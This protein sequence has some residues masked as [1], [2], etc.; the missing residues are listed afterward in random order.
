LSAGEVSRER[1]AA[2]K[3]VLA[4]QHCGNAHAA[5]GARPASST[6]ANGIRHGPY[7]PPGVSP[8]DAVALQKLHPGGGIVRRS[9]H[10]LALTY[11]Q[12][13]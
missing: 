8:Q 6:R 13:I 12:C 1:D 4:N 9:A 3:G 10:I 7:P 2:F 11:R 5:P